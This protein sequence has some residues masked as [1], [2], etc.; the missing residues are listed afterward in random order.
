M[1]ATDA[2]E[3]VGWRLT[4]AIRDAVRV[5][6]AP[7]GREP[8]PEDVRK[9]ADSLGAERA[10]WGTLAIPFERFLDDLARRGSEAADSGFFAEVSAAARDCLRSATD[11]LGTG[12]AKLRGA[13]VA[14]NH[15]AFGLKDILQPP[16]AGVANT[17]GIP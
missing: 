7:G 12:A 11:A 1:Q 8:D 5:T 3:K 6:L 9:V 17:G 10:Y 2:A 15:L 14:E 13:A 16:A 4:T